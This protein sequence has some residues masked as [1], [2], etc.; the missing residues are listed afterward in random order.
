MRT[1]SR[2]LCGMSFLSML[3]FACGDIMNNASFVGVIASLAGLFL[4]GLIGGVYEA[5]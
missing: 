2:F 5:E 3:F 4:F 1:I